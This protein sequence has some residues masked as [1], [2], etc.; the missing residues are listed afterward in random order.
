MTPVRPAGSA[1]TVAVAGVS[2]VI[3]AVPS[4]LV[5][6]LAVFLREDLAFDQTQ[7]GLAIAV[8]FLSSALASIPGGQV[9]ERVGARLAMLS[10]SAVSGLSMLGI[11]FL[12]SSWWSLLFWLAIAGL[13]NGVAQPAGN[14]ALARGVAKTKQ[15]FAFGVKQSAIPTSTLLAG[16][17]VPLVALTVGWRW[18]FVGV[19]SAVALLAVLMPR[20][21]YR[22]PTVRARGKTASTPDMP[23]AGLALLAFAAACAA[24]VGTSLGSFYV[25]GAV[26]AGFN[27]G[28]AGTML[29]VGSVACI[30][31][32]LLIGLLADRT[33][34]GHQAIM[35]TIL[36]LGSLGL[37]GLAATDG[38]PTLLVPTTLL[39]F[40]AAWGWPGL[41]NFTIARFNP[42]APA[43]ATAI[44][45]TGVFVGGVIGPASFGVIA[46]NVSFRAAWLAAAG[47]C[48]AAAVTVLL[49]RRLFAAGRKALEAHER[50]VVDGPRSP[51]VPTVEAGGVSVAAD[52]STRTDLTTGTDLADDRFE[53]DR[54]P[55]R[56]ER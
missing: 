40:T 27:P 14:L 31:S 21:P 7:L 24:S 20:D 41:F 33:V 5:G 25:E 4:F 26:S 55:K 18:A 19:A 34:R 29:A 53:S 10:A 17:A 32:R 28:Y 45:Q 2:S 22:S 42:S 39:A 56:D 12:A 13:A 11:A 23:V 8:F 46:E 36:L 47:A 44:T 48:A 16:A 30:A 3:G 51:V 9:T 54:S 49:S 37:I 15:G 35:V 50:R 43:A 1:R 52:A 38:H 6:A